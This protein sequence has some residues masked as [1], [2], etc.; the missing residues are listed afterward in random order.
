MSIW[1]GIS[2]VLLAI[3]TLLLKWVILYGWTFRISLEVK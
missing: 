1:I 2:F 3:L